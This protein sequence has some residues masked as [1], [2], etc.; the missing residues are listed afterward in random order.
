MAL[1]EI[2]PFAFGGIILL[3]AAASALMAFTGGITSGLHHVA[4]P[5]PSEPSSE[6]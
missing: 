6:Q 1:D 3:W 2:I 5:R 4:P